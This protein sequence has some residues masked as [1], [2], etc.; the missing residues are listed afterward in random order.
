MPA[1]PLFRNT[2][3]LLCVF[4]FILVAVTI[5]AYAQV[6]LSGIV[7]DAESG[8]PLYGA[9]IIISGTDEGTATDLTG[10]FLLLVDELPVTLA[11][12]YIGFV[13]QEIFVERAEPVRVALVPGVELGDL[14]IVGSRL[15]P[16]T[17]IDSPV[18]IDNIRDVELLATGQVTFDKMLTYTV[19]SFNSS[20]QTVSDATAHFDPSD[21]RGLGPSRTLVLVNGKRKNYSSLVYINDTPGKGEVGVDMKSIPAAAIARVEV[22]RDGASAQ[23]GSDAIA[24]VI[25]VVLKEDVEYTDIRAFSGITTEGD[26]LSAGYNVNT[27]IRLGERGFVNLTHS[28][29]DQ[30]ET[31]RAGEPCAGAV[32]RATCDGLFGGLLGLADTPEAQ[33]WVKA[34]PSLGM[35]IGQPNMT[36]ADIFYNGSVSLSEGFDLYSFG[37]LTYRQGLSYA[38][39]RTPY[40]IPDPFFFYHNPGE[41]YNGFHPTFETTILD[42]TLA[43]GIRG[44]VKGWNLDVS[45]ITGENR[46]DYKVNNSLNTDLG[47]QSP[48]RFSNGGYQF[49]HNVSNIDISRRYGKYAVAFGSEIR[50]ENFITLAGEEDSYYGSGA[51]SF[52]GLQPQNEVDEYRYNVGIYTDIGVD[53]SEDVFLGGALRYENYSDFGDNVTWKLSGRYRLPD[54]LGTIRFSTSTGF[55]APALHQIY[56]STVQ[57]ILSAGTVSHQGTFNNQSSVLKALDVPQLKEENAFNITGGIALRPVP[58]LYLS[59]DIYQVR[60]DDRIVYS[61]SITSINDADAVGQILDRFSITSF[62]FFTNAVNTVTRGVDLVASYEY[63]IGESELKINLAAN[64]N[65]TEIDGQISTPGPIRSAG[66]DIFDRKEQ[67]R[68]L[69]ARPGDKVLFSVAYRRGPINATLN[70]T[71]FGPVTW[72]HAGQPANDQTFDARVTTDLYIFY[73]ANNWLQIGISANNIF[74]IYPEEIET[75]GDT[76]TDFGGRFRYPWEVNQFGFNGTTVSGSL[77]IHLDH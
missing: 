72:Q 4:V 8:D 41:V 34:N 3:P 30:Q 28:F 29:V 52:P 39:Y 12:S 58:G 44:S 53:V 13:K 36:T 75:F 5:P 45:N 24:G 57:T 17:V 70:N 50:T 48:V 35:R 51:Q 56:L 64:L 9:N 22:L 73:D 60:V 54:D 74:N 16:R 14:V 42:N 20:Q 55:R 21:L 63:E 2:S 23:Y 40:W 33:E 7:T 18:P 59:A 65:T 31:N 1:F 37:G 15:A 19:P 67:S 6:T 77:R 32:D 71:R 49:K 11:V 62:K 47:A 27:G 43:V 76:I 46:V 26:G 61:S 69:S 25:N 10:R 66:V 68:L 38:A